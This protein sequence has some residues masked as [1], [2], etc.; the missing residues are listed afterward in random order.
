MGGVSHGLA[1]KVFARQ[2]SLCSFMQKQYNFHD[3]EDEGRY[4][5]TFF[6][7]KEPCQYEEYTDCQPE[8]QHDLAYENDDST[9][10]AQ[11]EVGPYE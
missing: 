5:S 10:Q 7:G 1:F 9:G 3:Y 6:R 11:D 8:G 2:R 4:E